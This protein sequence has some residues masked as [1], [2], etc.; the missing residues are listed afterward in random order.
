MGKAKIIRR[1]FLGFLVICQRYHPREVASVVGYDFACRI[2]KRETV[3]D[4][5][6]GKLILY[7]IE[8]LSANNWTVILWKVVSTN[9][10]SLLISIDYQH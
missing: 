2:T 6:F 4:S 9:W 10:K 7:F 8:S 5:I 1:L 3:V